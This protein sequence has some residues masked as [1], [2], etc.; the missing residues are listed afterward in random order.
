MFHDR[1]LAAILFTDI[2]G[3]TSMMQKDEFHALTIVRRHNSVVQEN[4][5]NHGGEVVNFYGDGCLAIF[6]SAC[7]AVQSAVD[8]QKELRNETWFYFSNKFIIPRKT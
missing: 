2:V 6:P 7:E 5:K 8:I 3:Y 1:R 4:S